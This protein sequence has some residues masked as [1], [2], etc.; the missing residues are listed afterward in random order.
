MRPTGAAAAAQPTQAAEPGAAAAEA[1]SHPDDSEPEPY[2]QDTRPC[3][4]QAGI[5]IW[6]APARILAHRPCL[7]MWVSHGML[8]RRMALMSHYCCPGMQVNR[9][10]SCRRQ[11]H[12]QQQATQPPDVQRRRALNAAGQ[13]SAARSGQQRRKGSAAR[14]AVRRHSERVRQGAAIKAAEGSESAAQ[15]F[16]M[17]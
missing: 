4:Y 16:R 13:S 15:A 8:L 7:H 14:L 5:C 3:E 6:T 17:S 10:K 11:R 1:A 2:G 9:R 12:W